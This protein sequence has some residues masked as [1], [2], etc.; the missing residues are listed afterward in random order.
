MEKALLLEEEE[1][2]E[3]ISWWKK[4]EATMMS[5]LRLGGCKS[6]KDVVHGVL[7]PLHKRTQVFPL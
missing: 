2:E 7:Y 5:C 3:E 1:E 4:E 6:K